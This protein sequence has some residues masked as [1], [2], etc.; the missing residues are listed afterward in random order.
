MLLGIS[1]GVLDGAEEEEA[2]RSLAAQ[3]QVWHLICMLGLTLSCLFSLKAEMLYLQ[4][5]VTVAET[6][7]YNFP[8]STNFQTARMLW[9]GP[10]PADADPKDKSSPDKIGIKSNLFFQWFCSGNI[11]LMILSLSSRGSRWDWPSAWRT[12]C[13]CLPSKPDTSSWA[14]PSADSSSSPTLK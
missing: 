14:S 7:L 8:M 11:Q 12:P 2:A 4:S 9:R 10:F 1:D 6:T 3:A 13:R 5:K